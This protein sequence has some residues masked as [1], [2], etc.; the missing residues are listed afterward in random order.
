MPKSKFMQ[1]LDPRVYLELNRLARAKG[2]D[3]THQAVFD[4]ELHHS[5]RGFCLSDKG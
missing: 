2:V 4:F 3:Q 5:S 1:S